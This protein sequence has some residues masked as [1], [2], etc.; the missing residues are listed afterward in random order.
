MLSEAVIINRLIKN[1]GYKEELYLC[2][3]GKRTIGVG[4]CLDTNPLTKDEI[5]KIGCENPK[6]ITK[7]QVY[8]LLRNDIKRVTSEM[9]EAFPWA[10]RL[11]NER[12]F[13]L[14]DMCFQMG[15]AKVKQFKKTLSY[16]STG[17][18]LQAGRELLNSV[19]ARQTPKRAIR[20]SNCFK[21]GVYNYD[22]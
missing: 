21:I 17:F 3:S 19:Y 1:E 13:S 12:Q 20:N 8:Y 18:Y 5:K 16:L 10:E 4:R 11:D 6:K 15:V 2:T 22:D 7:D 14:F 9:F